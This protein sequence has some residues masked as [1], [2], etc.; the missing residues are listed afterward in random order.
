MNDPINNQKKEVL[1]GIGS[2]LNPEQNII[3]ALKLLDKLTS[4]KQIA[5][6]WQTPAV[7]SE[8]PDYLNTAALIETNLTPEQFKL[9]VITSI[10]SQ[11]GEFEVNA[12]YT[13][14]YVK[15]GLQ[16]PTGPRGDTL[17]SSN[18]LWGSSNFSAF[19]QVTRMQIALLI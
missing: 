15:R 2:N 4:L 6:I 19:V 16:G 11:A 7:G 5:T 12:L 10:E 17:N 1:I 18:W 8:G 14:G 13:I 3:A 9:E